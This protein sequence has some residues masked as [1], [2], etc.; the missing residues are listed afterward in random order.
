MA[1][2]FYL[3]QEK[4]FP[5]HSRERIYSQFDKLDAFVDADAGRNAGRHKRDIVVTLAHVKRKRGVN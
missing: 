3:F 1:S 4:K 2:E 5:T